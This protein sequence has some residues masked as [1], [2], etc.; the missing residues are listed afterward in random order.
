MQTAPDHLDNGSGF[1][2]SNHTFDPAARRRD[3]SM[4]RPDTGNWSGM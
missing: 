4:R 1:V 2:F 3:A